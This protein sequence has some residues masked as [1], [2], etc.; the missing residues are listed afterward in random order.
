M[1][2][3]VLRHFFEALF[4]ITVNTTYK[5][6]SFTNISAVLVSH[7]AFSEVRQMRDILNAPGNGQLRYFLQRD[8]QS[9]LASRDMH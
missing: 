2:I 9:G 5:K 7:K 1:Y 4:V 3:T 8:V 6:S